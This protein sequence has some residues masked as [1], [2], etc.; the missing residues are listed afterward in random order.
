[1]SDAGDVAPS[2]ITVRDVPADAFIAA[3]AEVLKVRPQL[4]RFSNSEMSLSTIVLMESARPPSF[5]T[6][7]CH[8]YF[9]HDYF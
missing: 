6:T 2:C 3:Y 7:N 9:R 5:T 8:L 4:F 1:M